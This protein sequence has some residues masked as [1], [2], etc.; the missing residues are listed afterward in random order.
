MKF[1]HIEPLHICF[2]TLLLNVEG[3]E[4]RKHTKNGLQSQEG[5]IYGHYGGLQRQCSKEGG[6][7]ASRSHSKH[8]KISLRNM[9][10]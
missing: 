1:S 6:N 8:G 7:L 3:K 10:E 9:T 2:K 4:F 5:I